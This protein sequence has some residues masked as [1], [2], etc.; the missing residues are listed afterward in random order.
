MGTIGVLAINARSSRSQRAR[1]QGFQ[2]S[3][4][5]AWERT[6]SRRRYFRRS[7]FGDDTGSF[8]NKFAPTAFGQNQKNLC[9]TLSAEHGHDGD[10]PDAYRSSRS[11]V[12]MPCV[13]SYTNLKE[14]GKQG[15][16]ASARRAW[17]RTC[18]RRQC[19]RRSI[20]GDDTGPFANTFAPTAFGQNQ[21]N[22]CITPS[23]EHGHDRCSCDQ[24]SFLTLQRGNA[25]RDV[26]HKS[27][28][29]RKTGISGFCPQGVGANLFAKTVFQTRHFR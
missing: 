14:P 17:E 3:A 20:F 21:K 6:C 11:S 25:L 15:F 2:A 1:K 23:A 22:L 19:F 29:A 8:A 12:G 7:I 10:L 27:R 26:I 28:R 18:S 16:Q 4:R 13:T 24:R 9:M 5:R